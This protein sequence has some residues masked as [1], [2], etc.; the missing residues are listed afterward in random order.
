VFLIRLKEIP[1]VQMNEPPGDGSMAF[2]LNLELTWRAKMYV[3][4][5]QPSPGGR[6]GGTGSQSELGLEN[7][8]MDDVE[9]L[10]CGAERRDQSR[11]PLLL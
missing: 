3:Q 11:A 4:V 10:I 8:H 1:S 6:G 7:D 9:M 2:Y 5:T